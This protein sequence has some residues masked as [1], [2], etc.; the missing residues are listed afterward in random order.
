MLFMKRFTA[1]II[2][3]LLIV[4]APAIAASPFP[5]QGT[6]G[7]TSGGSANAQTVSVANYSAKLVGVPIRFIPGFTNTGAA[8][9]DIT[10]TGASAVDKPS[11]AGPTALTGRELV[12]TQI[13]TVIWDGT[14]YL[15]GAPVGS[16]IVGGF[17][18]LK[19]QATSDTA[20]IASANALTV[21][22]ANGYGYRLVSPSVTCASG[23]SGLNGLDTGSA[24]ASTWYSV[25]DVYNPAT[26]TNGC[27]LS[28]SATSPTLPSGFVADM[29]VGWVRSDAS[30]HFWRS[31]QNGRTVQIVAG[32]NPTALPIMGSGASGSVSAPTWTAISVSNYVPTTA[33]EIRIFVFATNGVAGNVIVAPNNSYGPVGFTTMPPP[34]GASSQSAMTFSIPAS[35][36]LESSNIYWASNAASMGLVDFGWVDNL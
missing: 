34:L 1:L 35:F 17:Q 3:A 30:V 10:S 24:A 12:A 21:S 20:V 8:T 13:A 23:T 28:L 11:P 18:N 4:S 33:A 2:A 22:D 31:I 32:T 27:L 14:E 29:R 26:L 16:Q 19:V 36:T 15:M 9:L 25:W 5:E 7:G 6:Y